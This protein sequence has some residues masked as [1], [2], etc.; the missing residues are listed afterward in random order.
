MQIKPVTILCGTNSCGKSSILQSILL[1]RQT[2]ESQISKQALLLNGG[3]VHL[4][5]F[6]N[7]IFEKKLDREVSFDFS[8]KIT[9]NDLSENKTARPKNGA[10]LRAT[11]K[12]YDALRDL[13]PTESLQE[14][15]EYHIHVNVSLKAPVNT[16]RAGVPMASYLITPIVHDFT[17]TVQALDDKGA[18]VSSSFVKFAL[19]EE[20][21]NQYLVQWSSGEMTARVE[22]SNISPL[23]VA[24]GGKNSAFDVSVELSFYLRSM[25]AFLRSAF[26][27]L[28]YIG[29]LREEPSR[30]YIYEDEVLE[31]GVK[32]ENAAY[33]YLTQQHS[34]IDDHY[35]YHRSTD[36]FEL[37]GQ[38]PLAVA[39]QHWLDQ[40]SI[41]SL[42]PEPSREIIYLN[43][44]AGLLNKTRVN[45]AD[46][47]FGVSQIFPI[48]LE[49]LRMAR[50][51]TLL[52]EQPEIHLHPKLQMQMA[53]YFV[54]LALS[55]KKVIAE[56]H[57]DHIVNRLV[58]RIVEDE[59]S[60]LKDLIAIYFVKHTENGSVFEE[61]KIDE[62]KGI[63][64]WPLDFFDQAA[65]EQRKIM[66][67]GLKK[68]RRRREKKK[69][70]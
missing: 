51:N 63:V 2:L 48:I 62:T 26:S 14:A 56:T 40:M 43:L 35:F 61:I 9:K 5:V 32:G 18:L 67:A 20:G 41:Q 30:R 23:F 60:G 21:T 68:R 12:R 53:D 11:S 13:L 55:G 49:G 3:L 27:S 1:I 69:A 25:N 28:T 7:I 24:E 54:A 66:Q 19:N 4:G 39:V 31:I 57:S 6:E 42:K 34:M 45:I 36:E 29:P 46:V 22:F 44:N 50:G 65:T 15:E 58:R 8:F 10:L 17:F 64:N 38:M 16:R 33:I 70:S 52:L 47:G 37:K 59:R